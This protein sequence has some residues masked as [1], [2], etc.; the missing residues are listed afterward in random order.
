MVY[1]VTMLKRKQVMLSPELER[2]LRDR[3]RREGRS[4]SAV[5]RAVLEEAWRA[6]SS[7]S[8]DP[9]DSSAGMLRGKNLGAHD[10]ILYGRR[11]E[12]GAG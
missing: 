3:A 8:G 2:W 12:R 4:V 5:L 1:D 7:A 6:G 10:E 9:L 11:K